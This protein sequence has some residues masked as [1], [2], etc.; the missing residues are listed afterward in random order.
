MGSNIDLIYNNSIGQP[1]AQIF[2]QSFG[3]KGTLALWAFVVI[4]QS[5]LPSE[6]RNVVHSI[7]YICFLG[8]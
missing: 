2:F 8:T 3:K 4:A 7:N 6:R 1:M 5:V